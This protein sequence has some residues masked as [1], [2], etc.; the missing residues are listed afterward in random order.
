MVVAAP[1]R[2]LHASTPAHRPYHKPHPQ[3]QLQPLAPPAAAAACT[4]FAKYCWTTT[5]TA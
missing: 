1:L 5:P 3:L 2:S 4:C